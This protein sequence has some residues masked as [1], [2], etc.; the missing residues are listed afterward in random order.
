MRLYL[1]GSS[2][3]R[4]PMSQFIRKATG[5]VDLKVVPCGSRDDAIKRCAKGSDSLLLIDSEGEVSSQLNERVA[6][7]IGRANYAF[8]MVQLMESWFLAD[9]QTLQ[10]YYGRGFNVRRL[11]TNQDIEAIPKGDAENGLRG[12]PAIA[13]KALRQVST[14]PRLARTNES[15]HRI[16]RLPQLPPSYRLHPRWRCPEMTA[17]PDY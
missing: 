5:R 15:L 1:E 16:Q 3:L 14:R 8:F 10:T 4:A 6:S 7:Q 11:P 9:R 2:K 12:A 17:A 13:P